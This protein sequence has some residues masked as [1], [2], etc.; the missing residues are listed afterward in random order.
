MVN[1][2]NYD[3]LKEKITFEFSKTIQLFGLTPLESRIFSYLYLSE[4]SMTLD[5]IG[6]ALGK[7]KTA[8]STNIRNLLELNLVSRVWKKGFRKDL[9]ETNKHL[10][11][12]FMDFYL[13][14]RLDAT[15]YQR[16]VLENTRNE[17]TEEVSKSSSTNE[18]HKLE[19]KLVDI[20]QFHKQLEDLIKKFKQY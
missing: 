13:N 1:N 7:S 2:S 15:A 6:R 16:E 14:K 11:K 20:L 3:D 9:Y 17:I 10:F 5:E 18:L 19:V 12:A 8:I 4:Q